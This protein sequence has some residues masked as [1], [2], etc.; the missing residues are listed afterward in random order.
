M[1]RSIELKQLFLEHFISWGHIF[2]PSFSVKSSRNDLLFNNSGMAPLYDMFYKNS[3]LATPICSIQRCVRLGGKHNDYANIGVSK[4][5]LSFFEMMGGFSFGNYNKLYAINLIWEFLIRLNLDI[6]KL[7]ITTHANDL[8]TI[9]IWKSIAGSKCKLITTFGEQNVWKAGNTGLC[10]ACTEVYYVNNLELWEILNIVF[11]THTQNYNS[12]KNLMSGC[13]DIG[14]GL[15]RVLA[16]LNKS[17]DVYLIDEFK[18]I[19]DSIWP[20]QNLAAVNR[21]LLD[22]IRCAI[23]IIADGV[24]PSNVGAGYVL[25]K[26]IRR[27]VAELLIARLS[28]CVL[29]CLAEYFFEKSKP[30]TF[31][32][33]SNV[34]G[35]FFSE[36]KLYLKSLRTNLLKINRYSLTTRCYNTFGI[37][38]ALLKVLKPNLL[39]DS[40]TT[41]YYN[42]DYVT[43]KFLFEQT[44][45]LKLDR[46]NLFGTSGGQLGDHGI[47]VGV[48]FGLIVSRGSADKES[49]HRILLAVGILNSTRA[50]AAW[51]IRNL[52]TFKLCCYYHS[53]LHIL[54]GVLNM[55]FKH[56][57]IAVAKTNYL[58]FTLELSCVS[59]SSLENLI[60]CVFS[61]QYELEPSKFWYTKCAAKVSKFVNV[62]A[63]GFSFIDKCCGTHIESKTACNLRLKFE[64]LSIT[65]L[66]I[67]ASSS[68]DLHRFETEYKSY[69]KNL[70]K[71]AG[72]FKNKTGLVILDERFYPL[73]RAPARLKVLQV[74]NILD[75]S[76]CNDLGLSFTICINLKQKAICC[77]SLTLSV[78]SKIFSKLTNLDLSLKGMFLIFTSYWD[79]NCGV[80]FIRSAFFLLNL[81]FEHKN[82]QKKKQ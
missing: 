59:F 21:I 25:R 48:N 26:L 7:I 10:G 28:L 40:R 69:S 35:V 57:E 46:T 24:L 23:I 15:E 55:H 29:Q 27:C 22:H 62:G 67:S 5:H 71:T 1:I 8:D 80:I 79:L 44:N 51:L 47:V 16:V 6:S 64:Q 50:G 34:S 2:I 58:G 81:I 82:E 72:N 76:S 63:F 4:Q 52:Y 70:A 42:R 32:S 20:G 14:I 3:T 37:P 13:I 36:I 54:I 17:F 31:A 18:Q 33:Y 39:K 49:H 60:R 68:L 38:K 11:I 19:S 30:E 77:S 66:R 74:D 12:C 45:Y 9:S 41:I 61:E 75:Y 53:N 56:V 43:S 78:M 65:K 73:A